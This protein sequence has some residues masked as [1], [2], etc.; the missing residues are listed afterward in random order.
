M[1]E[2][3]AA[4]LRIGPAGLAHSLQSLFAESHYL[5]HL[6]SFLAVG[7]HF[8]IERLDDVGIEAAAKRGIG[9]VN[10]KRDTL[11]GAHGCIR[12]RQLAFHA[13]HKRAHYLIEQRF[14]RP[15]ALNRLLGFVEFGRSHHLHGTRDFAGA[16]D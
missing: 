9:S 8:L 6:H 12:R 2:Q 11:H 3:R 7:F 4:V 5:R 13:L 10:H 14:V 15:H 1:V 16:V